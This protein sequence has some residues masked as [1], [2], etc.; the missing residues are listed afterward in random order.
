MKDRIDLDL[1]TDRIYNAIRRKDPG[2][3][4]VVIQPDGV[5]SCKDA[6]GPVA[7][8][9]LQHE[10]PRVVGIYNKDVDIEWLRADIAYL[11]KRY[12]IL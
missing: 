5:V 10:T 2:L 8:K 12:G 11:G 6:S 4:L 1:T 9:I 7:R 3:A